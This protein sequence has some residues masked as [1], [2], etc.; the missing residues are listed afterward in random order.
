VRVATFATREPVSHRITTNRFWGDTVMEKS[1]WGSPL[2]ANE[3]A[4]SRLELLLFQLGAKQVYGINVFKVKEVIPYQPLTRISG[5]HPLVKGI[6]TLRGQTMPIIDLSLAI[7]GAPMAEPEKGYIIIT[8]YNRSV[9]GFLIH[10]V[11]R[12]VNTQWDQ[13]QHLPTQLGRNAFVAAITM[14]NDDQIIEILDVEKVL[15]QVV[16]A[17]TEVSKDLTEATKGHGQ[18]VLAVDD[19]M[20]ARNQIRRAMEQLGMECTLFNDGLQAKE[21]LQGMLQEGIDVAEAFTMLICDIEMPR[22]DGYQLTTWIRQEPQL[23]NLYILLHSSISGAFN[24][25]MVQRTGA[26]QFLQ[27][28]HPDELARA[29]LE[30]IDQRG[31]K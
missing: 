24:A 31:T 7:G 26:N 4:G 14:I 29:V 20:V 1:R 13:V 6:A 21:A 5:S 8:E 9:H 16:H 17:S 10:R 2:E 19:S 12:I 22:M 15:D 25:E 3:A 28:Y 27:K 11:D 18:K 30:R 23:R